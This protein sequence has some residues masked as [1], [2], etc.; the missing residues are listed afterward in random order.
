MGVSCSR[1]Y[2][3]VIRTSEAMMTMTLFS[4]VTIS[5]SIFNLRLDLYMLEN[6]VPFT[7]IERLLTVQNDKTP[8]EVTSD[9]SKY[10]FRRCTSFI[11]LIPQCVIRRQFPIISQLHI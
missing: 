2:A 11:L 4:P 7:A 8:E 10:P 6:Q 9:L 5:H 1:Y 3:F